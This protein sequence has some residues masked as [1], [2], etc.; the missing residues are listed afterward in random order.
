[1][2]VTEIS[3]FFFWY[4]LKKRIKPEFTNELDREGTAGKTINQTTKQ[5]NKLPPRIPS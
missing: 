3:D 2:K 1:M 4:S 5:T